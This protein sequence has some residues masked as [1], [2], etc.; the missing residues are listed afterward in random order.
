MT[1]NI[2]RVYEKPS[3]KDGLRILVDRLWPR[4]LS[5]EKAKLDIW[6]KDI[7]P[8]KE[9]REWFGHDPEKWEEFKQKYF[10]EL[11]NNSAAVNQI[12]EHSEQRDVT[13]L[14]SS[15]EERY[16]NAVA[17]REYLENYISPDK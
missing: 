1:L 4:G 3:G 2:K 8:S 9:L 14:Y 16:N 12:L 10:I 5:R 17:L 11:G 13:M 15:K 7:A 6:L